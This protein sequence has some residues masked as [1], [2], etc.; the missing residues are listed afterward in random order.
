MAAARG[1]DNHSGATIMQAT[2]ATWRL[3]LES[4][5]QGTRAQDPVRRR[6]AAA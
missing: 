4:G 2:P 3:L 5:W 1:E 6:S